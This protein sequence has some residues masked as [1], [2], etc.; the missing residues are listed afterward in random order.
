MW[1]LIQM[2]QI[3]GTS[4]LFHSPKVMARSWWVVKNST[5]WGIWGNEIFRTGGEDGQTYLVSVNIWQFQG[6]GGGGVRW[7]HIPHHP[8]LRGMTANRQ[9]PC[10]CKRY[11]VQKKLHCR[12][13][14]PIP[15][16]SPSPP[17]P[18][19]PGSSVLYWERIFWGW[20]TIKLGAP[21]PGANLGLFLR[22]AYYLN[23]C[24]C[25]RKWKHRTHKIIGCTMA[26][27]MVSKMS[28]TLQSTERTSMMRL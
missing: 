1:L 16:Y 5:T 2:Q 26:P 7:H 28:I 19:Q 20:E 27:T 10:S 9:L 18:S 17:L 13:C 6:G 8:I 12:V 14:L 11:I 22:E 24:S 4:I 3:K 15:A 25:Q 21:L 23:F